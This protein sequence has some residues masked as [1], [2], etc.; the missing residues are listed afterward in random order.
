MLL[1]FMNLILT[2]RHKLFDKSHSVKSLES[3]ADKID[4]TVNKQTKILVDKY[5]IKN[6]RLTFYS[7][8]SDTFFLI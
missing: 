7:R 5:N 8:D 6:R 3:I 2:K 1:I 4:D